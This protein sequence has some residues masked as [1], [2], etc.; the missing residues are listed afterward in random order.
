GH[1]RH[2]DQLVVRCRKRHLRISEGPPH[3]WNGS[4][5]RSRRDR[6][7]AVELIREDK[8]SFRKSAPLGEIAGVALSG[9]VAQ[10]APGKKGVRGELE[11]GHFRDL[12]LLAVIPKRGQDV[13]RDKHHVNSGSLVDGLKPGIGKVV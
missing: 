8:N 2:L 1:D 13:M 6:E 4:S 3:L 12:L 10:A 7:L 5:G 11:V 9:L